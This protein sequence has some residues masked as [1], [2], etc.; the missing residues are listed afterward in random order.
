MAKLRGLQGLLTGYMLSNH[1]IT[2][3]YLP[4]V[5]LMASIK[6]TR[7][8]LYAALMMFLCPARNNHCNR[9]LTKQFIYIRTSSRRAL[10]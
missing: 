5:R 8:S 2:I 7:E 3:I 1:V 6:Y 4:V 9:T 10:L